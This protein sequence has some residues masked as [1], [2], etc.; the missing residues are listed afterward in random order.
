MLELNVPH[1]RLASGRPPVALQQRAD[2]QVSTQ[3]LGVQLQVSET[4]SS[5]RETAVK[6]D[7]RTSVTFL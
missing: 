3:L 5:L 6:S 7:S 1:P 4:R 2:T